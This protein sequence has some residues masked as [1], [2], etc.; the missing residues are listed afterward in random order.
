MPPE[1][2]S[3]KN[4]YKQ[5]NPAQ[6]KAVD[7]V[8]G[9]V[10]V[11]AGPGTGKTQILTLRIANI[12]AKT[13]T[14]PQ[15]IL[16]LTFTEAGVIAMRRRLADIIGPAAYRVNITTF[17]GFCNSIIQQYPGEFPHIIGSTS[18]TDVDQIQIM[19]G[20]IDQATIKDLRPFGD[21]YYY[22]K[23]SLGAI[24]DIKQEGKTPEEFS[25]IVKQEAEEL[26]KI[27]D[28][29]YESGAHKGKMKGK[30][31][32]MAK[33]VT[34][35]QELAIL[36]R[37]Y[38]KALRSAKLYDYSDMLMEVLRAL[39][40][41][42]ELLLMLQE[43]Y[44]YF[45]V[46]E[47]QDT[48]NAQNGIVELLA[49][50]HPQP[51]LFVVGDEKQAIYRFQG[52]SLENFLYFKHLYKDAVLINLEENYRSTQAI[53]D[54]AHGLMPKSV[55]L[56]SQ[57]KKA[58]QKISL[59]ALSRPEAETFF[60]AKHIQ[61]HLQ[62]GVSAEE[63]AVLY[64]DN[65]DAVG[66]A[67]ML[68][69][70]GIPFAIE[71][72]KNVLEDED[73]RKLLL[74]LKAVKNYGSAQDLLEMLHIDFLEVPPLD[75]YKLGSCAYAKRINPYDII[76]SQK[77][78]DEAGIISAV[79]LV[80]SDKL[81][82]W[83]RTVKNE[84]TARAFENIV[85]ESGF[86]GYILKKPD[87]PEK[88][89][90]VH[91]LFDQIKT[92]L[93][94]HKDYTLERFLEYIDMLQQHQ[95]M[96][97]N[98]GQRGIPGRVRLMTA[99]GSK[100]LEFEYVYI[101]NAFD[102]HWG[103]RRRTQ[104]FKLPRGVFSLLK[105]V[106]ERLEEEDVQDERNLFYVALTRAKKEVVI[107]Y[108]QT[109]LDGKE[110]LPSQFILEIKPELLEKPDT[111]AYE[112]EFATHRELEFAPRQIAQAP[113]SD[114]TFLNE[115]FR[116][117]GLSVTALNNY[118]KCPW[119]Y[120]YRNLVRIPEAPNKHLAY[121]NAVDEALRQYFDLFGRGE[122]PEVDFLLT[123]FRNDLTHRPLQTAD[124]EEALEKGERSLTGYIKKFHSSFKRRILNQYKVDGI[125]MHEDITINGKMDKIEILNDSNEVTV[126]DYKTGQPKSRGD[127]EGTTATSNG[128]YKRQ[129]VFYDLLLKKEGKYRM[130][131]GR[132][133]FI[134]PDK[135]DQWHQESFIVS[136][137]ELG[138]LEETINACIKEILNMEFWDKKCDN[139]QCRYCALHTMLVI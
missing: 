11:I 26:S 4:L 56:K 5:L 45:L 59:Y 111:D 60:L 50:F 121:G 90:K 118:L 18:I 70:L 115:L 42:N 138:R 54:S 113:L 55:P 24:S 49:S 48:N 77:L 47:H 46:D 104:H 83:K 32:D 27:D 6:K 37:D 14:P 132:I 135:K 75:I 91:Q 10:M 133:D 30:Y 107:S 35:N 74:I 119:Q 1:E 15:A 101:I 72:N 125:A 102:G 117:Q 20:V 78:L 22:L 67:S 126:V 110:L 128:N 116:R 19:Q 21:R 51:N 100:G 88:I 103:S 85:R 65:A 136:K 29:Y 44:Q 73:I 82:L 3:F 97:K 63:I 94:N 114:K 64:R 31:Q 40:E 98:T 2:S 7:T 71:S 8:E 84:D 66:I 76:R 99:H 123:R 13:D 68:E 12:I 124:L 79:L 131:S 127:I 137:D 25:T 69:R 93:E 36:Y 57:N 33:H 17:H 139:A 96:I 87:A 105:K 34:R 52:A 122:D 23:S 92:L 95:V 62:A 109:R 53:L 130:S 9:P 58:G 106:E 89:A 86:L 39:K 43:Q 81:A 120:F 16:A 112:K 129:L 41:N 134:D 80:L 28:L 108:S 61:E 38:Q